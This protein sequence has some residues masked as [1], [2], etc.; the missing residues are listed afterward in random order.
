MC[1]EMACSP[2]E[3]KEAYK[4]PQPKIQVKQFVLDVNGTEVTVTKEEILDALDRDYENRLPYAL[5]RFNEDN[6][7]LRALA[8]KLTTLKK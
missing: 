8:V 5:R 1:D 6:D 2:C 4:E 3:A 7:L